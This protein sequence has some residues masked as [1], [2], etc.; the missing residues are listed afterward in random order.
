M[1]VEAIGRSFFERPPQE[2][3]PDLLGMVLSTDSAAGRIVEVEAYDGFDDPGSH[4]YRGRTPR[5]EIMFGDPGFLY[6]YFSYGMHWCANVVCRSS[7]EAAAVLV[8]ALA[9]ERG[10]EVMRDRRPAARRDPDLCSGPAKLCAALGISGE[11][12]GADVLDDKSP[13]RLV[14][15][16]PILLGEVAQSTRIG[17]SAG[18]ELRW[19]WYVSDDPNVSRRS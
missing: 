9:P 17:L 7:G 1:T 2:V 18:R 19:R 13:V 5:T 8:R 10:L 6:V 14:A 4:A 11:H 3:A 15:P 12:N 16:A